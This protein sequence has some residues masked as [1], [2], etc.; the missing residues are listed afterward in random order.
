MAPAQRVREIVR[1]VLVEL[2]VFLVRNL[3]SGPRPERGR[4]VDDI[5]L[6]VVA[7]TL[8]G[9]GKCDVIRILV[10]QV[11]EAH[12]LGEFRL[13]VFEVQRDARA[14]AF[15][16]GG[17]DR[18]LALPV[19]FPAHA[20][21]RIQARAAAFHHDPVGHDKRGIEADAELA[22]QPGVLLFIAGHAAQ[23]FRGPGTCDGAEIL[24]QFVARHAD[25]VIRNA[26]RARVL[27]VLDPNLQI[28]IVAEKIGGGERFEA[29]LVC[30]IRRVRDQFAKEYFLVAVQGM[31]HQLQKLTYLGLEAECFPGVV[32]QSCLPDK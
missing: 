19:G 8:Q 12:G 14:A 10:D 18:E 4:G 6:G 1:Q 32:A 17:L 7:R 20:L 25:A 31:D 16:F 2:P 29:Q 5:L 11:L 30:R 9:Y 28:G 15:D 27:V 23:E 21:G 13:T 22:D 26:D 24:D 3:R